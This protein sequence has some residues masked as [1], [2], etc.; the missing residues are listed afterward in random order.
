MKGEPIRILMVCTGNICRSPTAEGVL[1]ARALA[2]GLGHRIAVASAGVAGYHVGDPPDRRSQAHARRRGY[3]LAS[4]RARQVTEHDF[5]L[6]DWL[7][8]M[9][10]GHLRELRDMAPGA[11]RAQTALFLDFV[12]ARR[13]CDVPDPYYGDGAG[14]EHVLDLVEAGCDGLLQALLQRNSDPT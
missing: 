6:H 3:D 2:A 5:H 8:A 9:D 1:R 12:P 7:L 10:R 13:G 4:L 14:F 11:C